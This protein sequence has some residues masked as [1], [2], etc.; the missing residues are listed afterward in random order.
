[1][2]LSFELKEKIHGRYGIVIQAEQRLNTQDDRAVWL[3]KSTNSLF[4]LRLFSKDHPT[5]EA[6]KDLFIFSYLKKHNYPAPKLIQTL[7][8]KD[9]FTWN[10]FTIGMSSFVEGDPGNSKKNK[11]TFSILGSTLAQLH[12]L[13]ATDYPYESK[14][15][16]R[17]TIPGLLSEI[18]AA[19]QTEKGKA[20]QDVF[21][22]IQMGL[23]GIP[24]LSHLPQSIIHTD[25][26]EGNLI[27]TEPQKGVLIDWYDTGKGTSIVDVGYTIAQ[28]CLWPSSD[29]SDEIYVLDDLV[30]A[31][32]N[33]YQQTRAL[34]E[35]EKNHLIW[36]CKFGNF[37]YTASE[38]LV[39][40]RNGED[41]EKVLQTSA[42]WKRFDFLKQNSDFLSKFL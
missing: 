35:D 34:S 10:D 1:M 3:I 4:V 22:E 2:E 7:D 41:K 13:N 37:G 36:T 33:S 11:D 24:T 15:E 9:C 23:E 39:K 26:W 20:W 40:S 31:F 30:T 16:P 19:L 25:T 18:K 21:Q 8:G 42:N 12:N 38:M 5:D 29:S 28:T 27:L 32:L 6:K 17:V 14:W